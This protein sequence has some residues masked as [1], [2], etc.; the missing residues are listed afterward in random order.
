MST[1]LF[2]YVM[3]VKRHSHYINKK[4]IVSVEQLTSTTV[5]LRMT[6]GDSITLNVTWEWVLN[7]LQNLEV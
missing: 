5:V 4:E 6:N 2:V 3:D 7:E 1:P